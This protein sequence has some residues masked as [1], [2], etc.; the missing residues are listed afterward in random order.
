MQRRWQKRKMEARSEKDKGWEEGGRSGERRCGPCSPCAR[1]RAREW[2]AWQAGL[3]EAPAP[4]ALDVEE[5]DEAVLETG[6]LDAT[7]H[8]QIKPNKTKKKR[9]KRIQKLTHR[10]K[11]N[12]EQR[13]VEWKCVRERWRVRERHVVFYGEPQMFNSSITWIA[14]ARDN[15]KNKLRSA[16]K[17]N[18][19]RVFICRKKVAAQSNQSVLPLK[20]ARR[21]MKAHL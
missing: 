13:P 16:W 11:H 15:E 7:K 18:I 6:P 19:G 1:G 9:K 10:L 21:Q 20:L 2:V 5:V 12:T 17:N 3:W 8:T 14:K 4:A